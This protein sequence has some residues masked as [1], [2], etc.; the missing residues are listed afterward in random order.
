MTR[1]RDDFSAPQAL[2]TGLVG[3]LAIV[4]VMV[5]LGAVI[6]DQKQ[7]ALDRAMNV[8]ASSLQFQSVQTAVA[9]DTTRAAG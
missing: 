6:A 8:A 4:A 2:R 3:L 7:E 9:A 1:N 5:A